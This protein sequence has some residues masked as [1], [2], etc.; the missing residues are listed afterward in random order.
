ML[1][2]DVMMPGLSGIEAAIEIFKSIPECKVLLFSGQAGTAELL[3]DARV[4]GHKFEILH[5][6]VHPHELLA[7]L[8]AL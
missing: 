8:R 3:D 7:R 1:L 5:K 6:P 2:S 4:R